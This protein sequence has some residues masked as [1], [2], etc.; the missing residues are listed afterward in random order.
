MSSMSRPAPQPPV[1]APVHPL[2]EFYARSGLALPPWQQVD[3]EEVPEPH[4]ALLVHENDMTS[5]LET[6]HGRPVHLRVLG[7]DRRADEYYREVV[8]CLEGTGQAVEFGAIR[9]NLDRFGPAARRLILEEHWPLGHILKDCAV[10]Y[11][12]RPRAFLRLASDRLINDALG[13]NGAQVLHGR[14]N[15]L[16][17]AGGWPLA[18]I[19]E[20]LPPLS[21]SP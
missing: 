15:T 11:S 5:T 17:D 1:T 6:F 16:F 2:D 8:L 21:P 7:R 4:K 20:I 13:L 14:R 10:P 12:S 18:E 19:V 9:I 3:A